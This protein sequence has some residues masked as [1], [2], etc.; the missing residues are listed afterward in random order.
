MLANDLK[1]RFDWALYLNLEAYEELPDGRSFVRSDEAE[2]AIGIF[3]SLHGSVE[4]IPP[5]LLAA[6]EALRLTTPDLF[7]AA[8]TRRVQLVGS[9]FSPVSATEFVKALNR[10]VQREGVPLLTSQAAG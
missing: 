5:A 8:L 1:E 6:S 3:E 4:K 2:A 10:D 7:E 9:D